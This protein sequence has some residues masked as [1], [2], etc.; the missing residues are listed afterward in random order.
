[1]FISAILFGYFGFFG[2]WTH[3]MTSA[4]A[5]PPNALIPMVVLLKWTLRVGACCFALSGGL[6]LVGSLLGPLVNCLVGLV[7]AGIFVIVAVWEWTNPQGYFSGVPPILLM[8]FALWNGHGSWL[9]LK[10]LRAHRVNINGR[11]DAPDSPFGQFS[12]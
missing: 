11:T 7:T 12:R 2:N 3:Q 6:A 1:M 5:T 4:N 8:I 10:E 9:G